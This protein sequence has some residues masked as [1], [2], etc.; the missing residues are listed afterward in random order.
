MLIQLYIYIVSISLSFRSFHLSKLLSRVTSS[1]NSHKPVKADLDYKAMV[2][3]LAM[4]YGSFVLTDDHPPYSDAS[5][6]KCRGT[7]CSSFDCVAESDELI[8]FDF[9]SKTT[10]LKYES[11]TTGQLSM[12]PTVRPLPAVLTVTDDSQLSDVCPLCSR[13]KYIRESI[14]KHNKPAVPDTTPN[15]KSDKSRLATA[16]SKLSLKNCQCI[17]SSLLDGDTVNETFACNM[18]TPLLSDEAKARQTSSPAGVCA[19]EYCVAH[20]RTEDSQDP[21]VS[22]DFNALAFLMRHMLKRNA[23]LFKYHIPFV[24]CEPKDFGIEMKRELVRYAFEELKIP[25]YV[26]GLVFICLPDA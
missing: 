14:W 6:C 17:E 23:F 7:L 4:V 22:A 21:E 2:K 11:D 12:H 1:A 13:N 5:Y 3:R 26:K 15:V 20:S 18:S 24:I 10:W 19:T 9:G 25:G 8:I 16:L